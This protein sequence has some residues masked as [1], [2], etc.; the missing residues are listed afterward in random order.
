MA[1]TNDLSDGFFT[2]LGS[3]STD[4]GCAPIDLLSVMQSESG[5][6]ADARNPGSDASGLIQFMPATLTGLGF[7]GTTADFRALS[8]QDQLPWVKKYFTPYAGA[9]GL[10]SAARIYQATFLPA[11]LSRGDGMD[12]EICNNSGDLTSA[13]NAN[14]VFD[15]DNT[16]Q[17]TVGDLQFAIVRNRNGDRWNEILARLDGRP[18]D[19]TIDLR[20]AEGL[21]AALNQLGFTDDAGNPLTVDGAI[22]AK[23]RQALT[24][25]QTSQGI[26]ANGRPYPDTLAA[27]GTALT[28]AGVAHR[29]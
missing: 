17:I 5:V 4:L 2:D 11:T 6:R 10:T 21:Q 20:R 1:L 3:I 26:A 19:A 16:G 8:A 7:T 15:V 12:V 28:T 24:K 29:A 23:T 18:V 27:L 13:Y 25:F 9:P 22:G 14:K